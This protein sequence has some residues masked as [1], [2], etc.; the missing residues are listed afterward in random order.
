MKKKLHFVNIAGNA[1]NII[2]DDLLDREYNIN[3]LLAAAA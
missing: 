1:F 3:V 2:T